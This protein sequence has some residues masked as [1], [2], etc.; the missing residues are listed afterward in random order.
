MAM[1]DQALPLVFQLC[2]V[3][4]AGREDGGFAHT[5]GMDVGYDPLE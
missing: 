1:R 5:P 2:R 3:M 4:F